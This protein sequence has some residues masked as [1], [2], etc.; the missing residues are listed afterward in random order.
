MKLFEQRLDEVDYEGVLRLVE[1]LINSKR[2]KITIFSLNLHTLRL[3]FNDLSFREIH[4]KAGVVHADGMMIVYLARF[5]GNKIIRVNG[6]ELVLKILEKGYKCFII[7]LNKKLFSQLRKKYLN[8]LGFYTPSYA[9]KWSDKETKKI[10]AKIEKLGAEVVLVGVSNPKAEKWIDE[11]YRK[12]GASVWMA[13]GSAPEIL[14][15]GKKRA[16]KFLQYIG[17]EWLWRLGLEPKRLWKRY[18]SDAIWLMK[19]LIRRYF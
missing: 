11:N 9:E 1:D 14:A 10:L 17:L 13:V 2:K 6:T 16:P 3:L 5:L 4:K 12:G 18:L 7:G 19:F 15:G 8:V